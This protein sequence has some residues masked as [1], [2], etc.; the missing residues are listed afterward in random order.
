MTKAL[1]AEIV[2]SKKVWPGLANDLNIMSSRGIALAD[3][4]LGVIFSTVNGLDAPVEGV[5]I[6]D[7]AATVYRAEASLGG[8]K[9][10]MADTRVTA[11]LG[12]AK[13]G[14]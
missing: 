3:R 10:L 13:M 2:Q 4:K 7:R 5:A 8:I 9:A 6:L 11:I 12:D 14:T 1:V